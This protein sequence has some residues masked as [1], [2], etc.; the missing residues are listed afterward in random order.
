MARKRKTLT[1]IHAENELAQIER[2]I[3]KATAKRDE[4]QATIDKLEE[5]R[6]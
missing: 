1:Q 5:A 6:G 3:E 2:F 4:L